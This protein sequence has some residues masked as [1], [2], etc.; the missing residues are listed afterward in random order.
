[1]LCSVFLSG[2]LGKKPD[3]ATRYVEVD[4]VIPG[5]TGTFRVHLIPVRARFSGKGA[6]FTAPEGAFAIVKGRLETDPDIGVYV[7]ME[8]E[9]VFVPSPNVKIIRKAHS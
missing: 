2:R 3:P 1:M 9:E 7:Q 5:P 8:L 6:I 4:E